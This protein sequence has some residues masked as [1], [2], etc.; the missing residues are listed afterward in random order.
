M[1]AAA[2]SGQTAAESRTSLGDSVGGALKSSLAAKLRRT[3]IFSGWGLLRRE[4]WAATHLFLFNITV[5]W[6]SKGLCP[7]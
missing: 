2:W 3:V 4:M 6:L 1:D 7:L 5:N